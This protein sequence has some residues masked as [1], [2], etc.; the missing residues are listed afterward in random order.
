[1][2]SAHCPRC[3][4][5]ALIAGEGKICPRCAGRLQHDEDDSASEAAS[6]VHKPPD[7][8]ASEAPTVAPEGCG[9]PAGKVSA[10]SSDTLAGDPPARA[11]PDQTGNTVSF[12]P[13]AAG[14]ELPQLEF[15]GPYRLLQVLGR[16]GMGVVYKA[17]DSKLNRPLA[18]KVL[19]ERAELLDKN[20]RERL[21]REAEAVAQLRH[22]HIVQI[23]A[24]G[25]HE[26]Q[27]FVAL[28][29]LEGGSLSRQLAGT[30][31]PPRRA[32]TLAEMLA[33]AVE[34]AHAHG[35]V[36]RD[37]KPGNIL[38]TA[39]GE[40]K[41]ADFGLAKRLNAD[42]GHTQTG[43]ILGTPSYMAPEQAKGHGKAVGPAAD[44]Y[45][46]GAV[47]YEM[48]TG[49]P[50]FRAASHLD[51]VLQVISL[52]P[53]SPRRLQPQ[54]P[55]DLETICLKCLRKEPSQ[56]YASA[57]AL[58]DD[59]HRFLAGEPILARPAGWP[60]RFV[61]W[62]RRRPGVAA[63]LGLVL[64]I[65]SLAFVLVSWQWREA[66]FA[67]GQAEEAGQQALQALYY[68]RVALAQS[69]WRGNNVGWAEELLD[70]CPR[71]YIGWE[72]HYLKR[73][74]RS[75]GRYTA[76]R[77]ACCVSPSARTAGGSSRAGPIIPCASGM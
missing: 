39:D 23:H 60:E 44:V 52:E 5:V 18:L 75:C 14:A 48:L 63:L 1:M 29:F 40:P 55:R 53:V 19:R 35:I 50:P 54:V 67:R 9:A 71:A 62:A 70:R 31:L 34:H 12:A 6:S 38:M 17:W 22:P 69:E 30:P 36:H 45:A 49:R 42:L 51:T 77:A 58:A 26:G 56:R 7:A 47:L 2:T 8:V 64:V 74:P 25:E 72:W 66:V 16:G 24:I 32:A 68:S 41:V 28:E 46:L 59:L 27:P 43:V 15:L 76:I 20:Q 37:L 13:D 21:Q 3:G 33:C 73:P 61:K 4:P 10:V 11:V 65:T 57:A